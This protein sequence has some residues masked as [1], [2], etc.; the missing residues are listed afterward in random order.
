M[1]VH[2]DW[3]PE[4]LNTLRAMWVADASMAKIGAA[5]GVTGMSVGKKALALGLPS[6]GLKAR[7]N[8]SVV[9]I[10]TAVRVMR[11]DA[12]FVA[13]PGDF[14]INLADLR[15]RGDCRWP[16]GERAP[17]QFCGRPTDHGP[18]CFDHSV[19]AFTGPW[20][21]TVGIRPARRCEAVHA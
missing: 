20:R 11:Q 21:P 15:P 10:A 13:P 19:R 3:T 8:S 1:S 4:R 6:R 17:Y 5:I 16:Y 7:G 14:V 12:A 9:T 2:F 18:Y